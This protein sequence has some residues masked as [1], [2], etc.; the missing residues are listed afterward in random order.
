MADMS[1][2]TA[3]IYEVFC[4]VQGEG[5]LVGVRQVF[6]RFRGCDRA[7]RYCDTPAARNV[8]GPCHI[9]QLAGTGEFAQRDNPLSLRDLVVIV[10]E[11]ASKCRQACH[12]IALTGGEPLLYPGYVA[13]LGAALRQAGHKVYL[14]T[15]GHL[16]DALGVVINHIDWVAMDVKL[17]ST[18]VEPVPLPV[19]GEFLKVARQCNCF[20]KIVVTDTVTAEELLEACNMI[21]QIDSSTS[22]TLQPVTPVADCRPPDGATLLYWQQLCSEL[23]DDVR[24]IPQCHRILRV[25]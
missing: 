15:A 6:V 4:S 11:L 1:G 13:A 23:L 21:A 12:S 8:S 3:P 16:P 19:F 7:C 20:V 5:P 18:L 10:E 2:S 14:E 9:E 25:R 17:P 22:V 24:I